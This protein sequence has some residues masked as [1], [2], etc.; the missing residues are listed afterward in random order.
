MKYNRFIHKNYIAI[1]IAIV[2]ITL[3]A[4]YNYQISEKFTVSPKHNDKCLVPTNQIEPTCPAGFSLNTNKRQ[5]IKIE[6]LRC[7]TGY[8]LDPSTN[9]CTIERRY[10]CDSNS[11]LYGGKCVLKC[12]AANAA[13]YGAGFTTDENNGFCENKS[14]KGSSGARKNYINSTPICVA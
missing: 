10:T 3:F 14:M 8:V 11:K 9:K 5:C 13:N 7:A 6:A 2:A 12:T 4:L 1:V